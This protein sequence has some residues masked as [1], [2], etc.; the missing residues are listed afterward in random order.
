[1]RFVAR[2]SEWI[3]GGPRPEVAMYRDTTSRFLFVLLLLAMAWFAGLV[4]APFLAG[5]TW[6]AVL[7]VTF[8]PFHRR[9][10]AAS[11]GRD[12]AATMVV[13]LLVAAFVVVPVTA[14]AF[15][16]FQGAVAGFEWAQSVREGAATGPSLV[17]QHPWV[18][19]L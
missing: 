3:S 12:W 5:L 17:E 15:K 6:A 9:L 7:V 1:M 2:T 13:T 8:R 19:E 10:R 4:I 14:A 18:G 11:G 16:A